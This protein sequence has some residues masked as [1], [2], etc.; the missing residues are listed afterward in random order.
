VPNGAFALHRCREF[1]TVWLGRGREAK[2]FFYFY[3]CLISDIH[4]HFP[5]DEFTMEVLRVLNVA[6]GFL[7]AL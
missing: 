6:P 4:V 5:F 7:V 2:F 3:S 1:E